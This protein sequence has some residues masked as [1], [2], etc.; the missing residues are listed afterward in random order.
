MDCTLSNQDI[1]LK[2]VKGNELYLT[3]HRGG[4]GGS[5][6]GGVYGDGLYLK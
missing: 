2:S 3:P 1:V 5:L 6:L 4:G